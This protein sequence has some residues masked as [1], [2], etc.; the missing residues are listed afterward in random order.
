MYFSDLLMKVYLHDN[1]LWGSVAYSNLLRISKYI[2]FSD[3]MNM[4]K[5]N[6]LNMEMFGE[7]VIDY[8]FLNV[9]QDEVM[10]T[11][12]EKLKR[13]K[14][15]CNI[16]MSINLKDKGFCSFVA[17]IFKQNFTVIYEIGDD[18]N[19][20]RN[21]DTHATDQANG[22]IS[23][24]SKYYQV[25][26][27]IIN[28]GFTNDSGFRSNDCTSFGLFNMNCPSSDYFNQQGDGST[29]VTLQQSSLRITCTKSS[30]H[31][32]LNLSFPIFA[33]NHSTFF[34]MN[35][36]FEIEVIVD[37]F[38]CYK[39]ELYVN[40][41][42]KKVEVVCFLKDNQV[43]VQGRVDSSCFAQA[44]YFTLDSSRFYG[45]LESIWIV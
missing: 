39:L 26:E 40:E 36:A 9:I 23:D 18:R 42:S 41:N 34:S 19:D 15:I 37:G 21:S 43:I 5:S 20:L 30:L 22:V 2:C 16:K 10:G 44:D 31:R 3:I 14:E 6:L 27:D 17:Y 24:S 29:K 33:G 38:D 4:C 12:T 1:E 32:S 25:N 45:K 7:R 28:I 35:N 8:L 13:I 11:Y